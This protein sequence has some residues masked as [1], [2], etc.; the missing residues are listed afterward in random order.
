MTILN[1]VKKIKIIRS[2][3]RIIFLCP[4]FLLY[5]LSP[6]QRYYFDN[7]SVIDGLAQSKVYTII[8]DNNDYIW[9][10]T[11]AGA[12]QFDGIAFINYTIENGL[13]EGGVRAIFQDSYGNIWLG[14]N[15]GGLTK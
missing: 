9:L 2:N 5:L 4:L 1:I 13:A 8:Q 3:G 7:Y 6:G 15:G 12:S 10:G 11:E 14:H